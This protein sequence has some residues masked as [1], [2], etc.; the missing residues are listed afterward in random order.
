MTEDSVEVS[1]KIELLI[2][3]FRKKNRIPQSRRVPV[4][5]ILSRKEIEEIP[6]D[7]FQVRIIRKV[8]NSRISNNSREQRDAYVIELL[9]KAHHA[10]R[11]SRDD[12]RKEA[13]NNGGGGGDNPPQS[14]IFHRLIDKDLMSDCILEITGK[15]FHGEKEC[16]I[17]QKTFNKYE[18]YLLMQYYF[19]YIH[20]L[21][22]KNRLPFCQY[23]NDKV[24][25]GK[26][27]GFVRSFNNYAKKDV[28]VRFKKFLEVN[29]NIRFDNVQETRPAS[30][31]EILLAPFQKIGWH[32]HFSNYFDTLRIQQKEV[33]SFIL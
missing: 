11:Q 26:E 6:K 15:I 28:F 1:K 2:D 8:G 12:S 16:Q 27:T 20:I 22:N 29:K 3:N 14:S 25:A 33:E 32:F 24:F 17:C 18:F 19:D 23:L 4:R 10:M 5:C 9:E 31:E 13:R 21:K 7:R 30:A